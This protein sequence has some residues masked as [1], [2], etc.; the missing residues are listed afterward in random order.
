[1]CK[2]LDLDGLTPDENVIKN[3]LISVNIPIK[4]MIRPRAGN[5]IYHYDDVKKMERDIDLC[6]DLNIPEIVIGAL[7]NSANIDIKLTAKLATRAH[8]MAVTFH[9]AIDYTVD[10]LFE[11]NRLSKIDHISSILT[12]GGENTALQGAS[13]ITK[14][15]N[16]FRKRFTIIAAGSITNE[17]LAQVHD[18]IHANEYHGKKIVCSF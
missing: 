12:S 3:T 8:P 17:N 7:T 15:I 4:V 13:M 2:D 16:K 18:V 10:I 6:K 1:L 5:F 9:K 11:L 14:M